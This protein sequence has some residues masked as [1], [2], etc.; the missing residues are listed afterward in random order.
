MPGFAETP[1]DELIAALRSWGGG[2]IGTLDELV[3][4]IRAYADIGVDEVILEWIGM[5]DIEGLELLAKDVLPQV[6]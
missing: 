3:E 2:F 1:L 5:D 4:Y 6:A